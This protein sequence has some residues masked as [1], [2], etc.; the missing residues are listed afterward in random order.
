M[1]LRKF[2]E[3]KACFYVL[4]IFVKVEAAQKAVHSLNN[5]TIKKERNV[6]FSHKCII[7]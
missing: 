4:E 6:Y 1:Y 2:L 5:K 3:K 7:C